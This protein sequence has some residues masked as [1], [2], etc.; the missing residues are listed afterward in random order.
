M[1]SF[2]VPNLIEIGKIMPFN[3]I[4]EPKAG[5]IK[6][7]DFKITRKQSTVSYTVRNLSFD[8]LHN[9]NPIIIRSYILFLPLTNTNN[10][11]ADEETATTG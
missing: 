2:C 4:V 6:M 7:L 9:T 8:L 1:Y 5:G 11:E 3:Y 10:D